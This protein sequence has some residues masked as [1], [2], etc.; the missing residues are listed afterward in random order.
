MNRFRRVSRA[1]IIVFGVSILASSCAWSGEEED[2]H[3]PAPMRVDGNGN[4]LLSAAERHTLDL[5]LTTAEVGAVTQ[6]K[7]RFG[8]VLAPPSSD[9]RIIAP[10]DG[11]ISAVDVALGDP[12]AAGALLMTLE[13]LPDAASRANSSARRS[14]L[15][16]RT[17]AAR[18]AVRAAQ[19]DRDRVASLLQSQLATPAQMAQAEAAL[20]AE[21]ATVSSLLHAGGELAQ[22]TDGSV[23]IR[24]P[25]SGTL[26]ELVSNV[27]TMVRRGDLLA[28]QLEPGRR[29]VDLAVSPDDAEGTSYVVRLGEAH[30]TARLLFR[31]LTVE[32]GM[33]RDRLEL[34]APAGSALLAGRVVT[35]EVAH[36]SSGIRVPNTALLRDGE[37]VVCFVA[38]GDGHYQRR[39]VGVI[40]RGESH[41]IVSSSVS[42]G[43]EVVSRGAAALL[44]ELGFAGRLVSSVHP[45][46]GP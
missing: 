40:A 20:V 29:W 13:P 32:E 43:E 10:I 42:A 9:V 17:T 30:A 25:G 12:V 5:Q 22:L 2:E 33:R 21:Q 45:A 44:G 24:A 1:G 39:G 34:S 38:S 31:G 18:A 7:L 4:V 6:T 11:R 16:G 36:E 19:I 8:H 28:R 27:G 14:E 3:G 26:V 37:N 23:P 46:A 35:V 41:S 15:R